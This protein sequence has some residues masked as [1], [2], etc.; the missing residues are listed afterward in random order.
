MTDYVQGILTI[1]FSF[2]LLPLILLQVGGIEG[3][4]ETITDDSMLSLVAPGKISLFFIMMMSFQALMGIVA[5]PF[6]M[7]YARQEKRSGKAEL[8]S[9]GV[10]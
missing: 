5:Q 1:V 2:M 3:V 6:I 8:G 4:R 7:G 9:L 10:I